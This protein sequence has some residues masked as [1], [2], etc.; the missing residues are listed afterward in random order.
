MPCAADWTLLCQFSTKTG[1]HWRRNMLLQSS[2]SICQALDELPF[3]SCV[4]RC[5]LSVM[6]HKTHKLTFAELVKTPCL[7]SL[8][9]VWIHEILDSQ[10]ASWAGCTWT[11]EVRAADSGLPFLPAAPLALLGKL[12][13]LLTVGV[14]ARLW[15]FLVTFTNMGGLAMTFCCVMSRPVAT[16]CF[17]LSSATS[18]DEVGHWWRKCKQISSASWLMTASLTALWSTAT[19]IGRRFRACSRADMLSMTQARVAKAVSN[20]MCLGR[21]RDVN[22][23]LLKLPH[24]NSFIKFALS[25]KSMVMLHHTPCQMTALTQDELSWTE[26]IEGAATVC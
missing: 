15:Y 1:S 21:P 4:W 17:M 6:L 10:A 5:H 8:Q 16:A 9:D 18:N 12:L 14:L 13:V 24:C 20:W 7:G 25:A 19:M 22:T 3:G 11:W 2:C 23:R 26:S